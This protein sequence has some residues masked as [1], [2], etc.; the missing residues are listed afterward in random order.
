ML[1]HNVMQ[2]G[3]DVLK[4]IRIFS[5]KENASERCIDNLNAWNLLKEFSILTTLLEEVIQ[6]LTN[7]VAKFAGKF[8]I[9]L[10]NKH[11]M[12]KSWLKEIGGYQ[13][14]SQLTVSSRRF[15]ITLYK[16]GRVF[17]L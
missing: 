8:V 3:H 2:A 16:L 13:R 9:E 12:L 11:H 17:G 7:L 15:L 4:E 5:F 10:D 14:W 6:L 1:L